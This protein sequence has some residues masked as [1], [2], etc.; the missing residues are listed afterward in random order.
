VST[1]DP[2]SVLAGWSPPG[3]GRPRI[4]PS[5]G[6]AV[7][8]LSAF[9]EPAKTQPS[10]TPNVYSYVDPTPQYDEWIARD[11]PMVGL[12]PRLAKAILSIESAGGREPGRSTAGALG[13]MQ[14]LESTA[15]SLGVDRSDPR[16][17]LIGGMRYYKQML[18]RFRD[19]VVAA[20]AYNAGPG[21]IESWLRDPKGHP[22]PK[23]TQ[24]YQRRM[25]ASLDTLGVRQADVP[26]AEV[27]IGVAQVAAQASKAAVDAINAAFAPH[28]APSAQP[29]DRPP[30]ARSG[31]QAIVGAAQ[32]AAAGAKAVGK[33]VEADWQKSYADPMAA[34]DAVFGVLE[35]G[36]QPFITRGAAGESIPQALL[37]SAYGIFHPYDEN[38]AKA[39]DAAL[40]KTFGLQHAQGMDRVLSVM[41]AKTVVD[42]VMYLPLVG[43]IRGGIRAAQV[44]EAFRHGLD[45]EGAATD[46][47]KFVRGSM[48]TAKDDVKNWGKDA[49]GPIV[50]WFQQRPD[51]DAFFDDHA[52][53]A[54]IGIEH[55]HLDITDQ[56]AS[57]TDV[58][59][60]NEKA[61]RSVQRA[62]DPATGK[63]TGWDLPDAV[64]QEYLRIPYVFGTK[65]MRA[66]AVREGYRA[67]EA[68]AAAPPRELLDFNVRH[69]YQTLIAPKNKSVEET[70]AYK[71]YGK[72]Y[73]DARK[74]QGFEMERTGDGTLESDQYDITRNL[75][76]LEYHAAYERAV[77]RDTQA[78]LAA[79]GGFRGELDDSGKPI[80]KN[81]QSGPSKITISKAGKVPKAIEGVA[82]YMRENIFFNPLPHEVQNVGTLVTIGSG[83]YAVARA[84]ALGAKGIARVAQGKTMFDAGT[85]ERLQQM[86]A[87]TSY[88]KQLQG[89]LRH[90]PGASEWLGAANRLLDSGETAQRIAVLE[91]LDATMGKSGFIGRDGRFVVTDAP[92]EFA[93]A[94]KL[95]EQMGNYRDASLFTSFLRSVGGPWAIFGLDIVPRAVG[96]AITTARGAAGIETIARTETS[97]NAESG[98]PDQLRVWGPIADYVRLLLDPAAFVTAPARL[99]PLGLVANI[100]EE[101]LAH[102]RNPADVLAQDVRYMVP[103][104][105]VTEAAIG[106]LVAGLKTM[107]GEAREQGSA[108]GEGLAHA[109][110]EALG[111]FF[112]T[113]KE[114][115][116]TFGRRRRQFGR[117]SEL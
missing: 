44:A 36:V 87:Y 73:T 17:N 4:G 116:L 15:Q 63:A 28:P 105:Q 18:D 19:P 33:T 39:Q 56:G 24:E 92:L 79:H 77:E 85:V 31:A 81:V 26:L 110:I 102:H 50:K 61:L 10:D 9:G 41:A 5:K 13:P 34:A 23:E 45:S 35:R 93:K 14:L 82:R 64:R 49:F 65:A 70:D 113:P 114:K 98:D 32:A 38:F 94:Q 96:K 66:D 112:E 22:L 53:H 54:R 1:T 29:T 106:A 83:P 59:D 60:A 6:D 27:G 108:W 62:V 86:G 43:E 69:D 16:A 75:I 7:D 21:T 99:G 89:I 37:D 84:L 8:A 51:L 25:V 109:A 76:R 47:I 68:E 52:K 107:A 20:L 101:V 100:P 88:G 46:G 3:P 12:D 115:P 30:I 57:A 97:Y 72:Q 103:G 67:T 80:L 48:L 104:G 55:R 42:P 2:A 71:V 58:V 91:H 90:V 111:P 74:K 95:R 11:A 40:L 117:R 78:Y